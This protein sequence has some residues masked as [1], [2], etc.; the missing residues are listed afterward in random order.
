MIY[1]EKCKSIDEFNSAS[2]QSIV[3]LKDSGFF[4]KKQLHLTAYPFEESDHFSDTEIERITS[5]T[6]SFSDKVFGG[7]FNEDLSLL[8]KF[9][10][11]L[12]KEALIFLNENYL[13]SKIYFHN[14]GL[15]FLYFYPELSMV[16]FLPQRISVKTSLERI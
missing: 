10:G 2:H 7:I 3:L 14:E 12:D 5:Y 1:I 16:S 13:S 11:V 15:D 8:E 6:K 9:F 4:V